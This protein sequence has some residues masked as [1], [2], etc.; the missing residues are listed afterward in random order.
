M[1]DLSESLRA[2]LDQ[3]RQEGRFREIAERRR[4]HFVD[5]VRRA[6]EAQAHPSGKLFGNSMHLARQLIESCIS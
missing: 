5:G 1:T 6:A 4:Y 2:E 3:L